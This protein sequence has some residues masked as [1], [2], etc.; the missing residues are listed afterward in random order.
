[1]HCF[2]RLC[3][4][5]V[6]EKISVKSLSSTAACLRSVQ[7]RLSLLP[8]Q[9]PLLGSRDICLLLLLCK[10]R[11]VHVRWC[12][13]WELGYPSPPPSARLGAVVESAGTVRKIKL[14][15][16]QLKGVWSPILANWVLVS[17]L[18]ESRHLSD[19][20][21]IWDQVY[22]VDLYRV[23]TCDLFCLM[24]ALN[25]N[26]YLH[27]LECKI[28]VTN[29]CC[30]VTTKNYCEL[31]VTWNAA[32][33]L[34][35]NVSCKEHSALHQLLWECTHLQQEQRWNSYPLF[36]PLSPE[37]AQDQATWRDICFSVLCATVVITGTGAGSQLKF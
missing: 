13:G 10:Q 5:S 34:V 7:I 21:V 31:K 6:Q 22:N 36:R 35:S 17:V 32:M 4:I 30:Q 27:Y 12:A 1:M 2:W 23:R 8:S 18:S 26:L 19:A 14:E 20:R 28:T 37:V 25:H 24:W 15:L 29:S 16:H 11:S 3:V 9:F 33:Q